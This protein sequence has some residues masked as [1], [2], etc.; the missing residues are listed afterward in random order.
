MDEH[1]ADSEITST[2]IACFLPR[3]KIPCSVLSL[4]GHDSQGAIRYGF[5]LIRVQDP[6]LEKGTLTRDSYKVGPTRRVLAYSMRSDGHGRCGL[7]CGYVVTTAFSPM[8]H[9]GLYL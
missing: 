8:R 9:A 7:R 6:T 2:I 3:A 5:G 4:L 1:H